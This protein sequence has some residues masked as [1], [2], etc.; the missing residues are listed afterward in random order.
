MMVIPENRL[1]RTYQ[2]GWLG[3]DLPLLTSALAGCSGRRS[4]PASLAP[5]PRRLR[6]G[7]MGVEFRVPQQ[8]GDSKTDGVS[9]FFGAM[10]RERAHTLPSSNTPT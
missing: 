8:Q 5:G 3:L 7:S 9:G 2:R 4:S 1:Y 10:R 6:G